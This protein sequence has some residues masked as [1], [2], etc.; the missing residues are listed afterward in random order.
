MKSNVAA[1]EIRDTP[2]VMN[3]TDRAHNNY[4]KFAQS[5][6]QLQLK[7]KNISTGEHEK[8]AVGIILEQNAFLVKVIIYEF[9]YVFIIFLPIQIQHM[10]TTMMRKKKKVEVY[11]RGIR[12][13]TGTGDKRCK[14]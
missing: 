14:R 8:N 10:R 5:N 3:D 4:L 1:V 9:S 13:D 6:P 12:Y 2:G 7:I 11:L